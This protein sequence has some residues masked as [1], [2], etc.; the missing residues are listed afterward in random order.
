MEDHH[1]GSQGWN[2]AVEPQQYIKRIKGYI[3]SSSFSS[4]CVHSAADLSSSVSLSAL[5]SLL[6]FEVPNL[7][8]F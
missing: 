3:L 1:W 7:Q 6:S 8:H 4:S 2:V 5:L